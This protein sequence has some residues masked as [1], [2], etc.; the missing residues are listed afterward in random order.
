MKKVLSVILASVLMMC[1]VTA[2]GKDSSKG[3]EGTLTEIVEKIYE[4]SKPEF[5]LVTIDVALDDVDALNAFTGLDNADKISEA[6]AS[7]SMMGS[8]AYSLVLVRVKDSAD[9]EDVA[10]AMKAGINQRKWICVEADQIRVS[11]GGDVVM[12]IMMSS[13]FNTDTLSV[14]KIT[15]AFK[16]LCGGELSVDLK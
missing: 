6:V 4:S 8:Q 16:S 9:A 14:D 12:L 2:C 3:P 10:K 11:A 5:N 1:F 15:D 13:E 7:E